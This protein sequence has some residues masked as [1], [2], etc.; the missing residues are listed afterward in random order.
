MKERRDAIMAERK[1]IKAEV[2]SWKGAEWAQM[3]CRKGGK[4]GLER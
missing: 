3:G 4:D 1:A 2:S